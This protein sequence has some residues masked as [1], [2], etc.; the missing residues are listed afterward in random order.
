MSLPAQPRPAFFSS[1][2]VWRWPLLG[3]LATSLIIALVCTYFYRETREAAQANL[4]VIAELK[5]H[6]IERWLDDKR[7][8]MIQPPSSSLSS[9]F[10]AWQQSRP[11]TREKAGEL[12]LERMR[13]YLRRHPEALRIALYD[14]QGRFALST[15]G[16]S[17][18]VPQPL[19]T[20]PTPDQR[21]RLIDFYSGSSGQA[22][23]AFVS[24]LSLNVANGTQGIGFMLLEIDPYRYLYPFIQTWPGISS[25]AETLLFR[26]A[27]DE[28]EFLAPLLHDPTPPPRLRL[29][30]RSLQVRAIQLD[31]EKT[32]LAS[33]L[34]YR[35][36]EVLRAIH[37]VGN[38]PWRV[39]AKLDADEVYAEARR[40]SLAFGLLLLILL[41]TLTLLLRQGRKQAMDAAS[42][43]QQAQDMQLLRAFIDA[44]PETLHMVSRDGTIK[45]INQTGA[46]RL[47]STPEALVG[48]NVFRRL[49]PEVLP[50]RKAAV[51]EACARTSHEPVTLTDSRNG[52]EYLS[53]LYP[54]GDGE[55][56]VLLATDIT[57][58]NADAR[59]QREAVRT[60][61]GFIDHLPGTAYVKD[62]ESRVLIANRGFKDLLGID[63]AS[64]IG[65]LSSEIFPGRF[66][67]SI[68]ADDLRVLAS[69]RTETIEEE[70]NGHVYESTKF[71]IPRDDA[72]P[73]L[74][75]I[76]L[77]VTARH[78]AEDAL[79][80]SEERLRTLGDNLPDSVLYQVGQRP[81]GT[82]EILYVS[83]GVE[84][85]LGISPAELLGNTDR[86]YARLEPA[87][88][89]ALRTALASTDGDLDIDLRVLRADQHWG[90]VNLRSRRQPELD[91]QGRIVWNGVATDVTAKHQVDTMLALQTQRASALLDLPLQAE[92]LDEPAFMA[93][94][95]DVAER[96]TSSQ[97]AFIHCVNEDQESIELVAWSRNTLAHYCTAKYDKH[98]PISQAGIW[99]DSARSKQPVVINDYASVTGK[100]GLPE[101]HSHLQRLISVPV[102]ESGQVRMIAGVGNKGTDYTDLD[103]ESV[104]LIANDTW[105]IMQKM[106]A[107]RAL[108]QAVQVVEASPAVCFRWSTGD[109]WPVLFVSDN[110]RRWGYEPA[111]LLAGRPAF[112]AMI[113][114]DDLARIGA[115]VSAYLADERSTY[116]QE[117]RLLCA[118]S[119]ELWVSDL[120]SVTL[121]DS[122]KPVFIDG[123]LT[124][125]SERKAHELLLAENLAAQQALN[126]KLEEAHNQLLQSEKLAAIGQLAA[127]VAH[128]LNNPIGFV[129]SNLGTLT[130]YITAL[131]NLCDAYTLLNDDKAEDDPRA[132]EI[133]RIKQDQDYNYL[134]AD[135]FPLLDES[136]EGLLRVRKIVQDL[137]DF[138]RTGNQEWSCADL[139]KGL[140]STLNI[141]TNEL[142]YKCT[143]RKEYG[144]LPE[145]DCVISQINQV[146]MNLLVNA[147]QAIET[148]GE[149]TL[150]SGLEGSDQVWIS[151]TDTGK[152]IDPEHMNRIFEPFFT[153]KPVG[154]G[155]GLGLSL[156][157]GI[158]NRHHGRI[159]VTSKPGHG[160]TFRIVLPVHQ[161]EPTPSDEVSP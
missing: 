79:R 41:G 126:K 18:A 110:V 14:E 33:G 109:G 32:V 82:R 9:A 158:I 95:Q 157:F 127:G 101:G 24:P 161:P 103:V 93:Y 34:D 131:V 92:Q 1:L 49:P 115:E 154:V 143:V 144:Q 146:F 99:A 6:E 136:R 70:F 117:Y 23:L 97:I 114:P 50:Q 84:R 100:K 65:K 128:E 91:D 150:R 116:T 98:Y 159:D 112:V 137:R 35:N 96:L 57:Q 43:A 22:R 148:Q 69:G 38:S 108:Q 19:D 133:V 52:V 75:G 54:L 36:V 58:R 40:E 87:E 86:F 21:A 27:G 42:R 37:P 123:V 122:G 5:A 10:A 60:L 138:S 74:G 94:A 48:S 45:L 2:H 78:L 29:P 118:D 62:S 88:L 76:T 152:G 155:T 160:T 134:R 15:D 16:K 63:P 139:H 119:T 140:D 11:A 68:V 25:S 141:V 132:Q 80:Q 13:F 53:M 145:V 102:I 28:V 67:E 147:A 12:L 153:T 111:D 8:G 55:H 149:I 85:L 20:R 89:P 44:V 59:A 17:P 129:T 83:S 73:A 46:T 77:D 66:G 113:H 4:A 7:S 72:P 151:I 61:Q 121:D 107:E 120:S 81:D 130:E 104:Q 105:R 47:G 125:I 51:E 30:I 106:R 39:I 71:I 135:I 90:W 156:V 56:A 142:K 26:P 124:D 64:M 3:V 31:T